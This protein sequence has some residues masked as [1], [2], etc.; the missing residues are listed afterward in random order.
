MAIGAALA[1]IRGHLGGGSKQPGQ[2]LLRTLPLGRRD[3]G[4][5]DGRGAMQ[6]HLGNGG[7]CVSGTP[8]SNTVMAG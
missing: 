8:C 1:Q 5:R 6:T 4:P 3:L 7:F 2:R